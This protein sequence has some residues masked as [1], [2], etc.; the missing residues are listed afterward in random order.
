MV[1]SGSLIPLDSGRIWCRVFGTAQ[2][3][4]IEEPETYLSAVRAFL[5]GVDAGA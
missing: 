1:N 5:R 3:A 2:M 4:M